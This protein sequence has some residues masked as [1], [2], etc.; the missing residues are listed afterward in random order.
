MNDKIK[1]KN[2]EAVHPIERQRE[3]LGTHVIVSEFPVD[4]AVQD[5]VVLGA[6]IDCLILVVR[7]AGVC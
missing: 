2:Y 3:A 1:R 5:E 6:V 7:S 4:K